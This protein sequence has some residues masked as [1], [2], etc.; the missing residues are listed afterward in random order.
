MR[1]L[2][3]VGRALRKP[4]KR[5][6]KARPSK[7]LAKAVLKKKTGYKKDG[8][9]RS[10]YKLKKPTKQTKRIGGAATALVVAALVALYLRTYGLPATPQAVAL[11]TARAKAYIGGALKAGAR[12]TRAGFATFL[13]MGGGGRSTQR[14]PLGG[15]DIHPSSVYEP[16]EYSTPAQRIP[17]HFKNN[18][19]LGESFDRN[20][21][22]KRSNYTD[23][24]EAVDF[25][26]I[27]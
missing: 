25:S 4:V 24:L 22:A 16:S 11:G 12:V 7:R 15:G 26:L 23:A 6:V 20:A 3:K 27:V 8:T 1:P 21:G 14:S 13:V 9:K 18:L 5:L 10:G 2:K 19:S 17:F